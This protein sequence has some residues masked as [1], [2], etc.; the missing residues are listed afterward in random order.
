MY[1]MPY[2]ERVQLILHYNEMIK[3][4]SDYNW[5]PYFINFMFNHIPGRKSVK[6]KVMT[7]EVV[8]VYSTLATHVVRK[9]RSASHREWLPIFLGCPDAPVPKRNKELMRNIRVNDGWHFNGCFLLPP[10]DRCRLT[11]PLGGHFDQRQELYYRDGRPLDRIHA[12]A[13]NRMEIADYT[14]KHFQRGNISSDDI[15]I[16]PRAQ[17][18]LTSKLD[19]SHSVVS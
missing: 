2:Q 13:M 3:Q 8:R 9:P 11:V 12:T 1:V 7:D 19:H 18:E 16:L 15:L 6:L 17:S 4:Y 10:P 14:L 5:R